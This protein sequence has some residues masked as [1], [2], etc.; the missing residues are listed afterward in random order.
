LV[1]F[2]DGC[3]EGQRS[4][5]SLCL[6][7]VFIVTF[8]SAL[9]ILPLLHD[10]HLAHHLLNLQFQFFVMLHVMLVFHECLV[11]CH[12]LEGGG[13]FFNFLFI[14]VKLAF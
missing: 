6:I 7:F 2:S 9:V 12:L 11:A 5:S 13:Q 14:A 1:S 3:F 8:L 10:L 4:L